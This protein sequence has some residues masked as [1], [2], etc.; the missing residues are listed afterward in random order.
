MDYETFEE[1]YPKLSYSLFGPYGGPWFNVYKDM[2][3]RPLEVVI[4]TKRNRD[5]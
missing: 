4:R 1:E 3:K 2:Y 5:E